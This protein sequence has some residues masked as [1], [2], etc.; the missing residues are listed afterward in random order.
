MEKYIAIN[1]QIFIF[2]IIEAVQAENGDQRLRLPVR[3]WR[4]FN[5]GHFSQRKTPD[6]RTLNL[7]A[8]PRSMV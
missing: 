4:C 2:S 8:M 5:I 7:S 1:Q 6:T 3:S